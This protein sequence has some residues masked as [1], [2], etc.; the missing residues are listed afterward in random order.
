MDDLD[1]PVIN[2]R[3]Q[4][5]KPEF[6]SAGGGKPPATPASVSKFWKGDNSLFGSTYSHFARNSDPTREAEL[7]FLLQHVNENDPFWLSFLPIYLTSPRQE[8]TQLNQ[9]IVATLKGGGGK[10][11]HQELAV[12]IAA[13]LEADMLPEPKLD[14]V[15][16]G[17]V[18]AK[19]IQPMIK[20]AVT[21]ALDGVGSGPASKGLDEAAKDALLNRH[22]VIAVL[23]G[24][25]LSIVSSWWAGYQADTRCQVMVEQIQKR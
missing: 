3:V 22:I 10:I 24:I 16:A 14:A 25:L 12:A 11:D 2:G 18:I 9:Q 21:D 8:Q 1:L 15:V 23:F 7:L 6:K 17:K 20:Q 5:S 19:A 4:E 13:H